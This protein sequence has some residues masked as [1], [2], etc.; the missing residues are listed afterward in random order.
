MNSDGVIAIGIRLLRGKAVAIAIR[1]D[2]A[3]PS[4]AGRAEL[5]LSDPKFPSTLRPFHAMARLPL[6]KALPMVKRDEA[7]VRKAASKSVSSFIEGLRKSKMSPRNVAIVSDD[8]PAQIGNPHLKA[9]ADER[10]LFREA[11]ASAARELGIDSIFLV[12]K[13]ISRSARNII[14]VADAKVRPWLADIAAAAGR[15]WRG[16]EKTAAVAAWIALVSGQRSRQ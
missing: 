10:R 14:G 3:T 16:E 8:E 5:M 15:P 4:Y 13:E 11:T 6:G 1:G 12:E 9:H 7:L 2:L